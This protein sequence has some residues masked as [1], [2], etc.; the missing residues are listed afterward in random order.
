MLAMFDLDG[1]IIEHKTKNQLPNRDKFIDLLKNSQDVFIV[2]ITNQTS[3][4]SRQKIIGVYDH[5]KTM[6]K[7]IE[8]FL[9]SKHDIYR[10]PSIGNFIEIHEM[11]KKKLGRPWVEAFYVGDAAG[12]PGDFSD[13]DIMFAK[14]INLYLEHINYEHRL[15]FY[16]PESY[17]SDSPTPENMAS[18]LKQTKDRYQKTCPT[19]I[20]IN[21]DDLKNNV[22]I[23]GLPN[24]GKSQLK[25]QLKKYGYGN[26]YSSGKK[27]QYSG[28]NLKNHQRT[29]FPTDDVT[30]IYC[31]LPY[32]ICMKRE[33]EKELRKYLSG[34]CKAIRSNM[35]EFVYKKMDNTKEL[36]EKYIEFVPTI[37][38]TLIF[39]MS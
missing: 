2:F 21:P 33:R 10:K 31:N 36:P 15:E 37:E 26:R 6:N 28:C 9:A 20:N 1:T 35:M 27:K 23:I 19:P 4:S 16:T 32:S 30:Y 39:E 25:E 7:S 34:D 14:N 29:N 18:V 13:S 3:E 11:A 8:M 12:R 22:V 17:F 5:Y 38:Q 24:S